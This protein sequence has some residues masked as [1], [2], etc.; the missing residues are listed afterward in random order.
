MNG[1]A[2]MHLN[3]G[4]V[5]LFLRVLKNNKYLKYALFLGV[6][7]SGLLVAEHSARQ[8]FSADMGDNLMLYRRYIMDTKGAHL[9]SIRFIVKENIFIEH[10]PMHAS[11][12]MQVTRD[13]RDIFPAGSTSKRSRA[14]SNIWSK[15][16]ELEQ[17]FV[18]NL[19][20]LYLQ[21]EKLHNVA[22]SKDYAAIKKQADIL[23]RSCKACHY[24]YRGIRTEFDD[25]DF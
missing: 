18:K 8:E 6:F 3:K 23:A 22:T 20:N 16:G 2:V 14:K 7:A 21:A 10:I 9:K 15:S 1:D 5:V 17:E 25:R 19:D 12:L 4:L 11:M 24:L 13:M